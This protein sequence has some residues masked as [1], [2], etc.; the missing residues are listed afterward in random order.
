MTDSAKP[1]PPRVYQ[2]VAKHDWGY[3]ILLEEQPEKRTFR[4]EDGKERSFPPRFFDKMVP[5]ELP[6]EEAG[7]VAERATRGLSTSAKGGARKRRE[8]KAKVPKKPT[9]TFE[10]QL[11]RFRT[12]HALGFDDVTYPTGAKNR[13]IRRARR[14]LTPEA[15]GKKVED[16]DFVAAHAAALALV[17]SFRSS[18]PKSDRER[19]RDLPDAQKPA[20][21]KALAA[22]LFAED[23]YPARFDGF[24]RALDAAGIVSWPLATIFAALKEPEH[25]VLVRG[26]L[27]RKQALVVD[28]SPGPIN[29]PR[30]ATYER[31]RDAA[32]KVR[33]RLLDQG[34]TPKD[35]FD[36]VA[37]AKKT[38]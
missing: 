7:A 35:F 27:M 30:G 37:F 17:D 18:V 2:H 31:L 32:E 5:A 1:R 25:H 28:V 12:A 20:F 13:A 3:A 33:K 22:L 14:E 11:A 8:P 19:L 16:A 34:E 15:F 29:P 38:L 21:A 26:S 24:V 4:F 10:E 36:V 23:P 6:P 9:I